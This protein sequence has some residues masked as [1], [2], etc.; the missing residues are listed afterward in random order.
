MK[1][2]T[3][4]RWTS[5]RLESLPSSLVTTDDEGGDNNDDAGEDRDDGCDDDE[6][7]GD[8]NNLSCLCS[9]E[10]AAPLQHERHECLISHCSE[11][12]PRPA[13][14]SLVSTSG[15][16]ILT[17]CRKFLAVEKR[18]KKQPLD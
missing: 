1:A 5:G 8:S 18:D 11:R 15:S 4:A 9:G 16:L 7:D 12:E 14:Q 3:T 2:S 13:V 17:S 6:V 10:E